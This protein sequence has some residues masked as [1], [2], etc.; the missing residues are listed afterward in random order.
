MIVLKEH[1]IVAGICLFCWIITGICSI[2]FLGPISL[3]LLSWYGY[4]NTRY[5]TENRLEHLCNQLF[6]LSKSAEQ[7]EQKLTISRMIVQAAA[8]TTKIKNNNKN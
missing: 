6:F 7:I 5:Y 4:N 8:T 3:Y 1:F 2:V